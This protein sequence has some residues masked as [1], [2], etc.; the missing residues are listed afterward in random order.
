ASAIARRAPV[1][2]PMDR[3]RRMHVAPC[4]LVFALLHLRSHAG[5]APRRPSR[6][7]LRLAHDAQHVRA[8]QAREVAIGPAA[9][10]QLGE[11]VGVAGDVAQ[12]IGLEERTVEVAA[13]SDMLDTGY[14]GDVL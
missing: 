10:D 8:R 6:H 4:A 13:K 9:A 11:E 1:R 3:W 7:P 14:T 12:A 5:S 2:R